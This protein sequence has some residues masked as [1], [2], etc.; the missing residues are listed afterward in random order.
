VKYK[1]KATLTISVACE[2]SARSKQEAIEKANN[3]CSELTPLFHGAGDD[4][5]RPHMLEVEYGCWFEEFETCE[6]FRSGEANRV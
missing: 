3:L 6:F 2:V 4:L 5:S 1:V